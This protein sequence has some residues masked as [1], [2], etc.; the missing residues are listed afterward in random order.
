MPVDGDSLLS[1]AL[2]RNVTLLNP[3]LTPFQ[4]IYKMTK[5]RI[6]IYTYK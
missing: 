3:V 1:I 6:H 4:M 2:A 5:T